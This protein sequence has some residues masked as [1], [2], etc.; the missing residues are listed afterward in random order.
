M[1]GTRQL[2]PAA[3]PWI[4]GEPPRDGRKYLVWLAPEYRDA[5][6]DMPPERR[7]RPPMLVAEED[8][9]VVRWNAQYSKGGGWEN[10]DSEGGF[11][12]HIVWWA[13]IRAPGS[14]VV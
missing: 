10:E 1:I 14:G 8:V 7:K 6:K 3:G 13:E 9:D 5:Y 11:W 2:G 4:H 12:R